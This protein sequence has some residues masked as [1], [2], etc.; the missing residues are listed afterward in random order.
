VVLCPVAADTDGSRFISVVLVPQY[1]G[2]EASFNSEWISISPAGT[3]A[4]ARNSI[5]QSRVAILYSF[6][7]SSWRAP[8]A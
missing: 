6:D 4:S 2:C 7:N 5:I 1:P 8:H 3:S